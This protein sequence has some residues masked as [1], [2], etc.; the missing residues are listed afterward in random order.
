MTV[1]EF[2][3]FRLRTLARANGRNV[4]DL[5]PL[6]AYMKRG[7]LDLANGVD[8]TFSSKI[9]DMGRKNIQKILRK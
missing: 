4:H 2:N 9:I 1:Q 3:S 7:V 6:L 8:I 5:P